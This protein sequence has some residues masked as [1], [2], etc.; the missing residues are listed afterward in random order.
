MIKIIF[1]SVS[2]YILNIDY[3]TLFL[4]ICNFHLLTSTPASFPGLGRQSAGRCIWCHVYPTEKSL[5]LQTFLET[6]C[7]Q[8]Y[9]GV[10]VLA[11]WI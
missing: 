10:S 11:D 6:V 5:Q 3:G 1:Y 2:Y 9:K 4:C 7:P 8:T